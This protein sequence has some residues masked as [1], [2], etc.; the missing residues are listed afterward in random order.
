MRLATRGFA[1][2]LALASSVL[3]TVWVGRTIGPELFGYY[4]VTGVIVQ[5]GALLSGLGLGQTG[6]MLVSRERSNV[7]GVIATVVGLRTLAA[8]VS[9]LV[10]SMG[11]DAVTL[12]DRL[13]ALVRTGVVAW[14]ASALRLDWL[15][16][17]T[18]RIGAVAALRLAGPVSALVV[19]LA[20]VH[21]DRDLGGIG[22]LI[23]APIATPAVL[24]LVEAWRAGVA[25]LA[26]V[27]FGWRESRVA[28][29]HGMQFLRG[30]L[31]TLATTSSD[32]LFLFAFGSPI[33]VGLYDAAYRVIQ[34]FYSIAA[35][36]NDAYYARLAQAR[37]S[38]HVD[39][40][41]FRRYL[42]LSLIATIPV[43][44]FLSLHATAIVRTLYGDEFAGAAAALAVLGW[45]ISLGFV[46]GVVNFPLT[47]FGHPRA[48]GDAV[49][50]GGL[51]NIL[52]NVTLIPALGAIGA[53]AATVVAKLVSSIVGF[54]TFAESSGY[55][56][57]RDLADYAAAATIAA[58]VS[59][60]VG[61]VGGEPAAVAAF[62]IVYSWSLWP[63]RGAR[64]RDTA[65]SLRGPSG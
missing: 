21:S 36:V 19:A 64:L 33:A 38:G 54:R 57:A 15:F 11:V 34:P 20:V 49:L 35:V 30:E 55:R 37:V 32:R 45:V 22:A 2:L 16:V 65:L 43:G 44:F 17:A 12:D 27:R 6:A 24:G 41:V 1:E 8:A 51:A 62:V 23:V 50:A 52:L 48:Y 60:G 59:V 58:I 47:A 7:G 4:A 3:T 9:M 56:I 39:P 61:A 25:P 63:I 31:G 14:L 28:L 42:D 10:V 5:L 53:A 26:S 29:A 18:G 40:S 13:E 46:S